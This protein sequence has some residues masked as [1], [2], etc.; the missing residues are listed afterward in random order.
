M[1]RQITKNNHTHL[2]S[3]AHPRDGRMSI[4]GD[5][6]RLKHANPTRLIQEP[7]FGFPLDSAK[8]F[9]VACRHGRA[10]WREKES[11]TDW[12]AGARVENHSFTRKRQATGYRITGLFLLNRLTDMSFHGHSVGCISY[13]TAGFSPKD[14]PAPPDDESI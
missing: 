8:L 4:D 5:C 7:Q 1:V 13:R 11:K 14:S 6:D 3:L 10:S 12:T 2:V 9:H